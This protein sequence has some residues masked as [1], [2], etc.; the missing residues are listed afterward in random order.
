MIK[1]IFLIF[2]IVL[3]VIIVLFTNFAIYL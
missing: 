1:N 3:Y 2:N